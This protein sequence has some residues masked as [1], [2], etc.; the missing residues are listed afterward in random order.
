MSSKHTSTN[1]HFE[2][3]IC[4]LIAEIAFQ[5]RE[6][7]TFFEQL[8]VSDPNK[9]KERLFQEEDDMTECI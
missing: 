6:E 5:V 4:K 8:P 7:D 9:V 1:I 3:D 2:A